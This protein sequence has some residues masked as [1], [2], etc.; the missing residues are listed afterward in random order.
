MIGTGWLPQLTNSRARSTGGDT[1]DGIVWAAEY[2]TADELRQLVDDAEPGPH[3][4]SLRTRG[5]R[6]GAEEVLASEHGCRRRLRPDATVIAPW[7]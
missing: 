2:A 4:D 5:F 7:S 6:A 3:G 1:R